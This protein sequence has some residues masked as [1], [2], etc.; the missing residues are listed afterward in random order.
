MKVAVLPSSLMICYA[1]RGDTKPFPNPAVIYTPPLGFPVGDVAKP[2]LK[3]LIGNSVGF[4]V[5]FLILSIG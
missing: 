3:L 1:V 5:R 4:A 2:N